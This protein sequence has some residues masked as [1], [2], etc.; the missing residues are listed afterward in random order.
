[1]NQDALRGVH[2]RYG[3]R[4]RPWML[5]A[6]LLIAAGASPQ[7]ASAEGP[8]VEVAELDCSKDDWET[9]KKCLAAPRKRRLFE[10]EEDEAEKKVKSFAGPREFAV[11]PPP[12]VLALPETLPPT[13]QEQA[14]QEKALTRYR[15][16]NEQ[17]LDF[18][19]N[20]RDFLDAQQFAP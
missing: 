16:E 7:G 11:P 4:S 9:V 10:R 13:P 1:M 19:R 2:G 8:T 12:D 20:F 14:S 5:V 15:F 3:M 17:K 6:A 18:E